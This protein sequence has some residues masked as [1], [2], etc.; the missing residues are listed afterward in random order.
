M[1]INHDTQK[2]D[3]AIVSPLEPVTAGSFMVDL[4][5]N[6]I[7]KLSKHM[8]CWKRYVDDAISYIKTIFIEYVLS[9]LDSFHRKIKFIFKEEKDNE[10]SFSDMILRNDS[11]IDT[12]LGKRKTDEKL[13]KNS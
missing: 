2:D 6:V 13:S 8:I 5:R 3:V 7:P 12:T 1:I 4:E 9:R 10:N 11:S